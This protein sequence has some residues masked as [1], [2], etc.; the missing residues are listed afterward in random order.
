MRRFR[1]AFRTCVASRGRQRCVHSISQAPCQGLRRGGA[2][3]LRWRRR[4]G[5][6]DLERVGHGNHRRRNRR[7][8]AARGRGQSTSSV[9]PAARCSIIYDEIF[10]QDKFQHI[11]VR[12]EQAAVHAADAYSR[13]THEVGVC[14]V[15]SGPGVTNA[16]TGIATAYMD[17][18]P[19]VIISWPGADARDRPGRIPGM[20][21]GR[22]HAALRQAQLPGQG[23]QGPGRDDGQG[24]PHRAHRPA[25]AGAGRH[26]EGRQP[27]QVQVRVPACGGDA[28]VQPGGQGAS[29]PDQEGDATDPQR[30]AADDLHRRRRDPRQRGGRA[31]PLRR[32][33]RLT[34][35]PTP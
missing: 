8:L 13:S 6:L 18:I 7:S 5:S 34:R 1:D 26:P 23:R 15:T 30:R 19:M 29:G 20:R 32:P 2:K 28:L 9:T 35:S 27:R 31:E 16:V 25:R 14:L 12:H 22:H 21:H 33:P 17:S 10:K 24:L 4:A 11:L 3:S